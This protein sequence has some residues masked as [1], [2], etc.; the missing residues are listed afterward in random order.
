MIVIEAM[1]VIAEADQDWPCQKYERFVGGL[2]EQSPM[3][4][5]ASRQHFGGKEVSTSNGA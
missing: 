5:E 4:G 2:N 3:M 1:K